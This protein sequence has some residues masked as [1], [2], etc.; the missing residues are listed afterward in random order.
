[1]KLGV[2]HQRPQDLHPQR[3]DF[4]LSLGVEAI[5]VRLNSAA[6]GYPHLRMFTVTRDPNCGFKA[7]NPCHR[8]CTPNSR[9]GTSVPN[10]AA[11]PPLSNGP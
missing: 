9:S 5:E 2:S 4:L 8:I 1:M 6:A 7:Q 3:F 11:P 10:G